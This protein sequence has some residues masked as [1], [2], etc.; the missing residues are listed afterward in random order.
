MSATV[1]NQLDRV[2]ARMAAAQAASMRADARRGAA[3]D[4]LPLAHRAAVLLAVGVVPIFCAPSTP[5][6]QLDDDARGRICRHLTMAVS[7]AQSLGL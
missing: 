2:M 3:W 4:A 5:W 6:A 7:I 1:V